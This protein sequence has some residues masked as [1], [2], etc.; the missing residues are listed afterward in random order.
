MLMVL[1]TAHA[2]TYVA[3]PSVLLFPFPPPSFSNRATTGTLFAA[4][5]IK[6]DTTTKESMD[7]T[8]FYTP[9]GEED[10]EEGTGHQSTGRESLPPG[11]PPALPKACMER[12]YN[13]TAEEVLTYYQ[14]SERWKENEREGGREGSGGEDGGG[15]IDA[16]LLYV[17][18]EPPSHA[19]LSFPLLIPRSV[20]LLHTRAFFIR[21]GRAP[22]PLRSQRS[23]RPSFR[24]SRHPFL[25]AFIECH[26]PHFVRGRGPGF[27][28]GR[29]DRRRGHWLYHRPQ[30]GRG[31]HPGK[32]GGRERGRKEE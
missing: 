12:P 25:A 3:S 1:L 31:L 8:G 17:K 22:P 5:P 9:K 30:H 10:V 28:R 18:H 11:L 14:V 6:A 29:M 15:W 7:T 24:E 21:I 27:C 32:W 13:A 19:R 23:E 4:P 20:G 2:R 16:C 26:V